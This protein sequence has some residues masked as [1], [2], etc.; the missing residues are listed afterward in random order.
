MTILH[1]PASPLQVVHVAAHYGQTAFLNHIT[2]R[3]N[4][5]YD[6]PDNDGRSPLHLY[7]KIALGVKEHER[8]ETAF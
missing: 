4:A 6:A 2:A 7:V 8:H 5:D 3:Y 1:L